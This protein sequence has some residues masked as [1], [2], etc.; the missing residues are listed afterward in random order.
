[1]NPIT[2]HV[3]NADRI[4]TEADID[5]KGIQITFADQCTGVVPFADIPEIGH[6]DNLA[7]V[8]LPNPYEVVLNSHGGEVVEL[9]WDF[10]R[11]YCDPTYRPKAEGTGARGREALGKRIR[12]L[13]EGARMTQQALASA[14][15]LGRVTLVRIET[16]EQS[17]RYDTLQSIAQGLGRPVEDVLVERSSSSHSSV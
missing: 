3:T 9:P 5:R 11:H 17:P 1:M 16:G 7:S 13:R 2:V 6:F 14:A 8:T 15:G 10:V 4:M 12:R